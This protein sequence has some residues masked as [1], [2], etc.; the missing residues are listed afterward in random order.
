MFR[1]IRW[2]LGLSRIIESWRPTVIH[3][4]WAFPAGSGGYLAAK[5]SFV[6]LVMTLRGIEHQILPRFGF[7]DCLDPMIE[8]SLTMALRHCS[9]V[10]V[11][12]QDS[13][14]RLQE[15]GVYDASKTE[16]V[17]H[18]VDPERL[19]EDRGTIAQLTNKLGLAGRR[20]VGCVAGMDGLRKGQR[21]LIDA[22]TRL[23]EGYADLVVVFV[24]NG[25]ERPALVKYA[26]ARGVSGRVVFAGALHPMEVGSFMRMCACTVLPTF[27]EAF[28]NVVFE[29]LLVGTPVIAARVGAPGDVLREKGFGATFTAG[30]VAELV[31]QLCR[32]MDG[33]HEWAARAR[34]G[35]EFV[36]RE[37]SLARRIEGFTKI[38]DRI[39]PE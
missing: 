31:D 28:G 22:M 7:G 19:R 1:L 21:T 33:H 16:I 35:G 38:Y 13:I 26:E 25:P 36:R 12:C 30:N 34:D 18:A 14:A 20:V 24:G 29:S 3:S 8:R 10:T 27:S 6:P 23:P 4:H 37:M 11:C 17:Y 15:L 32:V 9:A 39:V 2:N 5:A